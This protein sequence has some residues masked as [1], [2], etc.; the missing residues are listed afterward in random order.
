MLWDGFK[1]KLRTKVNLAIKH[2]LVHRM[3]GKELLQ[4]FYR[5][6]SRNMR[7]LGSPVHSLKWL[8]GVLAAFGE[9]AKVGVIYEGTNPVAAGIIL[10][11]GAYVTNPWASSLREFNNLKPNM[12]LYWKFLEHAADKGFRYF[13]FGRSTPGEGTYEFKQQWGAEPSPLCW[14]R[15]GTGRAKEVRPGAD[16]SLRSVL[17]WS[18]K[19]LPVAVANVVGP[20]IRKHISL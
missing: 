17:E 20:P 15:Q 19:K 6:F 7:D 5:V 9:A 18:W 12:L 13:D 11:H 3:G 16:V 2:G 1:S 14:F 10:T 4:D 8:H